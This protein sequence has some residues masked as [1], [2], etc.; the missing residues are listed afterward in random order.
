MKLY[1]IHTADPDVSFSPYV[2]RAIMC[3]HHKG[4]SFEREGL[5]FLAIADTLKTEAKTV[6]ALEDNGEQIGDS[7]EIAKYLERTYPDNPLFSAG[8]LDEGS[9]AYDALVKQNA[10]AGRTVALGIFRLLVLDIHNSLDVENQAYFRK[11]R[12]KRIGMT[13]EEMHAGRD[14]ILAQVRQSFDPL[15]ETLQNS[16]YLCGASPMWYD[17]AVFGKFQWARICSAYSVLDEDDM[18]HGWIGRML[19]LYGGV[20]RSAKLAY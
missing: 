17:H 8:Q 19:D 20:A 16:D 12:E 3:L 14:G 9:A 2:W 10:W 7:F 1:E 5:N 18:L 11:T 15:R 4:L 13:L 6:P